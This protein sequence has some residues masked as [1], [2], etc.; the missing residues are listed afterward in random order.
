MTRLL[1]QKH[2]P[3]RI[4]DINENKSRLMCYMGPNETVVHAGPKQEVEAARKAYDWVLSQISHEERVGPATRSHHSL[5]DQ[6]REVE[7]YID[8]LILMGKPRGKCALCLDR[9][10]HSP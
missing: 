4:D 6:V 10:I 9:P 7:D 1:D 5:T 8:H 3:S 2:R